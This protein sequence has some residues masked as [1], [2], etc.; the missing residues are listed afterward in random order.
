LEHWRE[1]I[2]AFKQA[3]MQGLLIGKTWLLW[4][5]WWSM[6]SSERSAMSDQE[7]EK[8]ENQFP[9]VSGS[10]FAAARKKV[11]ESGQS[12]FQ[13]ENGVIYEVFPDGNRR[14]VKKIEPPTH[15]KEG[16]IYKLR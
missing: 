5:G 15:I 9:A 10:A 7:I 6:F 8:L 16:S 2:C 4:G 12:V 14:E 11:L 1:P 13:S 3:M